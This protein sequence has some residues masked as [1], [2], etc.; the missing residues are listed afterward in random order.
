MDNPRSLIPAELE[1]RDGRQNTTNQRSKRAKGLVPQTKIA[2]GKQWAGL[3]VRGAHRLERAH[4]LIAP[5]LALYNEPSNRRC[6]KSLVK[7]GQPLIK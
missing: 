6:R 1:A 2:H 7:A 3:I 4:A 5:K